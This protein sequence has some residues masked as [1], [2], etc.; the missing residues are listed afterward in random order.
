VNVASIE[1][2]Q[3]AF[4]P[5]V[6]GRSGA[7][8][9]PA[10]SAQHPVG[11]SSL[12]NRLLESTGTATFDVPQLL[13]AKRAGGALFPQVATEKEKG[14]KTGIPGAR[15]QTA[16]LRPSALE[17][18]AET[19]V[20]VQSGKLQTERLAGGGLPIPT[21]AETQG[22]QSQAQPLSPKSFLATGIAPGNQASCVSVSAASDVALALQLTWRPPATASGAPA[23]NTESH[24]ALP[25]KI[26]PG[27]SNNV[28]RPTDQPGG[29][30]ASAPNT[31]AENP[32]V[33]FRG[34]WQCPPEFLPAVGWSASTSLPPVASR[35]IG[36]DSVVKDEAGSRPSDSLAVIRRGNAS[37]NSFPRNLGEASSWEASGLPSEIDSE[38]QGPTRAPAPVA[39]IAASEPC[40]A[41]ASQSYPAPPTPVQTEVETPPRAGQEARRMAESDT[42][43]RVPGPA[44][45]TPRQTS[46]NDSQNGTSRDAGDSE[47][48]GHAPRVLANEKLAPIQ[49]SHQH[50]SVAPEGVLL[51]RP[52]EPGGASQAR[53]KIAAP[54]PPQA[55]TVSPEVETTSAVPSQPI[56]QISLRLAGAASAQVDVQVEER[57]GRVQVAVRTAD[58][59]LAK[60]L[61]INLGDLVGRLEEKGFKTEA[62]TPATAQPSGGAVRETSTSANSQSH[63]DDSGFSA[64]QQDSQHGQRESNQRQPGR[65]KAQLNATLAELNTKTYREE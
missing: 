18:N 23:A 40:V 22:S 60:S 2:A 61:Q 46:L 13:A 52:T 31:D 48:D 26:S 43:R 29:L 16:L 62:W 33:P 39:E 53:T 3:P 47:P 21:L 45:A 56:R 28:L 51:D 36:L 24:G 65:W 7:V 63:S 17:A 1:V 37:A 9:R 55:P 15:L 44:C 41:A 20:P 6:L 12:I 5:K 64:G 11:F 49:F 4:N 42:S 59:D 57:A 25:G 30:S 19:P 35:L 34:P 58:P 50:A 14:Q 10:L 32:E 38:D 54:Q 8:S 27:N